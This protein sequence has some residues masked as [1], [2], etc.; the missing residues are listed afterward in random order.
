[1]LLNRLLSFE[2]VWCP[3]FIITGVV[4]GYHSILGGYLLYL[5]SQGTSFNV[6]SYHPY[7]TNWVMATF[8][9]CLVVAFVVS[10]W[11]L[12]K[13]GIVSRLHVISILS[14]GFAIWLINPDM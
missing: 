13:R 1:M 4:V 10:A 3:I 5:T 14:F 8:F 9:V 11:I 12:N 2:S 7:F 6:W